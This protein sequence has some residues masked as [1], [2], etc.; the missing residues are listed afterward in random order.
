MVSI[1][2]QK[3]FDISA[4]GQIALTGSGHEKLGTVFFR[5]FKEKNGTGRFRIHSGGTVKT[6][7]SGSNDNCVIYF[8]GVT[9]FMIIVIIIKEKGI[10]IN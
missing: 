10:F 8:H 7:G 9:F 1:M 6:C 5:F 4:M 2:C 3:I